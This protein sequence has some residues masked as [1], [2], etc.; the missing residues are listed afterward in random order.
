MFGIK[1][2]SAKSFQEFKTHHA[3]LREKYGD[4]LKKFTLLQR[5]C[6]SLREQLNEKINEVADLKLRLDEYRPIINPANLINLH[7]LHDSDY[8]CEA[9][10]LESPYCHK[11]SFADRTICVVDKK[12]V[13]SFV[14]LKK[15]PDAAPSVEQKKKSKK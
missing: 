15:K 1:I 7:V 10:K 4:L 9:C 13:T 14:K 2:L 8:K 11:L 5:D 3:D 12:H 6:M